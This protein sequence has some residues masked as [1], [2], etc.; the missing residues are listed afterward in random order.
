[1]TPSRVRLR[2]LIS[3]LGLVVALAV[4]VILPAGY[5]AVASVGTAASLG[6]LLMATALVGLLSG[7]LAFSTFFIV[8]RIIDRVLAEL[9]TMQVRYRRLFDASP[10]FTVV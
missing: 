3:R 1:M 7:L 5:F 9:E 6:K 4:T 2:S 10:F 8:R